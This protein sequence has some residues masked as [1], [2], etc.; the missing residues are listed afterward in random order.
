M[1]N[2]VEVDNYDWDK[3]SEKSEEEYF[4]DCEH[5]QAVTFDNGAEY[6]G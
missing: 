1:G 4:G 5:R 2:A 3:V 6:T